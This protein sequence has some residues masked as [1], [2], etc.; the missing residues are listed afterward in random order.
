MLV[1][2]VTASAAHIIN[3]CLH[4]EPLQSYVGPS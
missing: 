3:L 4:F 2:T 1:T